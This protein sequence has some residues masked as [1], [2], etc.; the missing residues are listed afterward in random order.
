MMARHLPDHQMPL[1]LRPLTLLCCLLV[2]FPALSQDT[3]PE[4][5]SGF[6][7]KQA[8]TAKSF[9]VAAANPLAAQAGYD[10][11]KKGGSAVDAAIAVQMV[12]NL[13]EPQSSGIGGGGFLLHWD[14]ASRTVASFDGR[15]TAPAAVG[16]DLFLGP[17]GNPVESWQARI[18]GRAV[19]VP[20]V[21][22]MLEMAHGRYGVLPWSELFQPAIALAEEGF[23]ISPRMHELT[24]E[25]KYLDRFSAARAYLFDGDG[26]PLPVRH[27]LV[28]PDF[29]RT[30]RLI[31]AQGADVFYKGEIAQAIVAAVQGAE[32]NPGAMTLEDLAGYEAKQREPVCAPYRV[33]RVCGMGPPSTGGLTVAMILQLLEPFDM[34]SAGAGSAASV[35]LFAEASRLAYA[36]RNRYMA[37]A[38]AVPVPVK[39]LM[40]PAYLRRRAGLID[41]ARDIGVAE[42][43][44][45]P[46]QAGQDTTGGETPQ[47]PSTSHISVVDGR[48]NAVSF[49]TS[50]AIGFGSRLMVGGFFLNNQ[51]TD[52]AFRPRKDGVAHINRPGPGKRPRSSMAPTLVFAPGGGL[53]LV[54][55]SPGG[56]SI[57]G[58][59][60]KTIVAVLDWDMDIQ[61]AI[62]LPHFANRNGKATELEKGTAAVSLRPA[63]EVLGHTIDI[64]SH[65]SGLHGIEVTA[66]GLTGGADP[67]REGIVLGD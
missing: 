67:R 35:H 45:L 12:L 65:T 39:D 54:V 64:R 37:D 3:E 22:R 27:R 21:L 15:E 17:D 44:D 11:L 6:V 29:A 60:A 57:I 30:L 18:G 25:S 26:T 55:G 5:G 48:G 14:A 40:D 19:G 41:P 38:D 43:G 24:S 59:V 52:F 13:V 1:R 53:R 66:A 8:R 56:T 23:E 36:D 50:I 10:I 31:A 28:N 51:L 4:S 33:F 58:Y 46:R 9:M 32:E 42:P 34:A 62:A 63:L 2:A 7:S 49:T 20:G 47:Q 16:E 61:S